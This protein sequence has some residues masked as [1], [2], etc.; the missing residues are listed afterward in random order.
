MPRRSRSVFVTKRSSPT[1]WTRVAD[2]VGQRLPAVPVLLVH[3]VLDREDRVAAGEIG[4]VPGQLI[5]GERAALVLELVRAVLVDL[6]RRGVERDRE[7]L[8]GRDSPPP[9]SRPRAPRAPPRWTP[10]WA[11]SRPRRRRLRRARGRAGA[12]EVVEHLGAHAQ[13]IREASRADRH[14]HELLEV[15]RVVGMRA[16]VEHVHHR[17]RQDPRRLAAEVAPQRLVL[18][19][20]RGARGGER[21]AEDRVRTQAALVRRAVE[22][23]Q[24]PVERRTGRARRARRPPARSRR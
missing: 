13:R 11:R 21:D 2:P 22:V 24:R 23:D 1:S 14:D 8:A 18:L 17:H 6:A 15:D 9:R 4:P 10:G 5:G 12:L 3:P 16:A 19:R 20:R 7:V